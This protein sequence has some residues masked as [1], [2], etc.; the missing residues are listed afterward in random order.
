M[1]EPGVSVCASCGVICAREGRCSHCKK[2]HE[3]PVVLP[4]RSDGAYWV[5]IECDFKCRACGFKVPLNHLDMD[6]AMLCARCGLEQAFEVVRWREALGHAHAV[7]DFFRDGGAGGL[8]NPFRTVGTSRTSATV[9]TEGANAL[10]ITASPGGPLC[11]A[12]RSPL[13]VE[14][15]GEGTSTVS[16]KACGERASYAVPAAARKM[17]RALR[18]IVATEHRTDRP[19]VTVEE[20]SGATAIAV[21]CPSCSAPLEV[22]E[23]SRFVACAY[24][25][26][27]S[28][29]PDRTWF[30][31]RG[32][33]PATES[34]WLLF[35]GPSPLREEKDE[36]KQRRKADEE[37]RHAE[38]AQRHDEELRT[39]EEARAREKAAAQAA[40]ASEEAA[41][42][43]QGERQRAWEDARSRRSRTAL[44]IALA[45]GAVAVAT[46]VGLGLLR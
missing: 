19:E 20:A 30:R 43:A 34:M 18:A 16:C 28:R 29:I 13:D 37:R 2:P 1:P 14:I 17:A 41:H 39:Q 32:G 45:L 26:T 22:T 25:K 31:L 8:E 40:Q 11:T 15:A 3:R 4:P 7:G 9:T 5:C 38:K 6:G 46:A 23:D 21:K 12:C 44:F 42:L 33:E 35:S 27:T 36:A 10:E 24:C